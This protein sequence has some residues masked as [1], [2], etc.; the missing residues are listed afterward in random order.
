MFMEMQ[1]WVLGTL[2]VVYVHGAWRMRAEKASGRPL[3][4]RLGRF[5]PACLGVYVCQW[6]LKR[7]QM[8]FL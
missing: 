5:W 1:A 3:F 6:A 8:R 2:M 4:A 7:G